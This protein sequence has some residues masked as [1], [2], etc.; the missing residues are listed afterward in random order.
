MHPL[1]LAESSIQ[2]FKYTFMVILS[3]LLCSFPW[4]LWYE[5]LP[6]VDMNINMLRKSNVAPTILE[7]AHINGPHNCNYHKLAPLGCAVL[8]HKKP[9]QR[10]SCSMP[11]IHGWY[12]RTSMENFRDFNNR[13]K[14]TKL[15]RISDTF[16]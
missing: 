7:Y 6:Q 9:Y 14:E 5:L 11:S 1:N 15:E 4:L 3:S 10:S 16:F 8:L 2:T 13:T 12:T